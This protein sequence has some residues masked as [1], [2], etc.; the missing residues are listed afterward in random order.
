MCFTSP[1]GSATGNQGD[2]DD[3]DAGDKGDDGDSDGDDNSGRPHDTAPIPKLLPGLC[4]SMG[5]RKSE[6]QSNDDDD[7]DLIMQPP[8]PPNSGVVCIHRDQDVEGN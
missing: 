6:D 4:V 5:V 1:Q 2:N 8:P 3:D 7:T